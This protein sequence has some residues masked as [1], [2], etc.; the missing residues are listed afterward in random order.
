MGQC[1]SGVE[2]RILEEMRL[3]LNKE[4]LRCPHLKHLDLMGSVLVFTKIVGR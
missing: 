4:F 3:S 2:Q 1:L